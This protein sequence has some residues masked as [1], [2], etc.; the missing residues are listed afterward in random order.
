MSD[1]RS[2]LFVQFTLH[3][4]PKHTIPRVAQLFLQRKHPGK[5][6][7]E[8]GYFQLGQ[9]EEAE[10]EEKR[11]DFTGVISLMRWLFALFVVCIVSL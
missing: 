4:L 3:K 9:E 1:K 7:W 5:E 11:S 8:E 10:E 2:P 6:E